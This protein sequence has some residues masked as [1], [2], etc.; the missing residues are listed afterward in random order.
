VAGSF[1]V[2]AFLARTWLAELTT[3]PS[4]D[5]P[6]VPVRRASAWVMRFAA[7]IPADG[8]VLDLACGDGR[9]TRFLAGRGHPVTAVDT[10]VRGLADLAGAPGIA[11]VQTDLEAGEWPF[12]PGSFAG[13]VVTNYLHRP[14]FRVLPA[15][16][17]PGGILIMETFAAGNERF[18]RPR[19]PDFLL[20]P[21]ELLSAFAPALQV[22]AYEHGVEQVPRP[23]VRQRLVALR[24]VEPVALPAPPL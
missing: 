21:G 22:V 13:I 11:V 9:H 19:N 3:M 2:P 5:R 1:F 18:G 14:H 10:D 23:A 6:A 8:R 15:T 24:Q 4:F 7:L 16:L 17:Q 20:A 12:A